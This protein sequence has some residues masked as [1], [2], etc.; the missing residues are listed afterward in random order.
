M[1]KMILHTGAQRVS[2]EEVR[3]VITPPPTATWYP[4]NHAK[5]L[6]ETKEQLGAAGFDV[7]REQH[8]L[9]RAGD[10]YFSVLDL[11]NQQSQDDYS[12]VVGLR[13]SHDQA[14][15]A[16]IAGG[17]RV[18][19]CDNLAF[20]GDEML[21]RKHTRFAERDIKFLT[22]QLV[23]RLGASFTK[24]A[25]HIEAYK[26]REISAL[27][28]HHLVISAVDCRAVLPSQIPNILNRWRHPEFEAFKPR[29]VWSFM[30]ACTGG[31][32]EIVQQQQ[33]KRGVALHGLFDGFC[34]LLHN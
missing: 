12:W 21:Q 11:K 34:D 26:S 8:A 22:S 31:G 6:D 25:A 1:S 20:S 7:V 13:N 9:A 18:F 24:T 15:S 14:F 29:N 33:V 28:A 3:A 23:G 30:N 2:E 5:F 16:A 10:R 19:V 32:A 27:E 17:T 4:L